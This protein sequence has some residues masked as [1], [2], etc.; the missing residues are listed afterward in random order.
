MTKDIDP[1]VLHPMTTHRYSFQMCILEVQNKANAG[2]MQESLGPWIWRLAS[3]GLL[4]WNATLDVRGIQWNHSKH[5]RNQNLWAE[6][7]S[8]YWNLNVVEVLGDAPYLL[9]MLAWQAPQKDLRANTFIE[10]KRVECREH[11]L[12]T[13]SYTFSTLS[14]R[15]CRD[16][17]V[18]IQAPVRYGKGMCIISL[19]L[20]YNS[21]LFAVGKD[22]TTKNNTS[23]Q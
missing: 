11:K 19:P 16:N 12:I 22:I 4:I 10:K 20:L 15:L 6:E 9:P 13:S 1:L 7:L 14:M 17:F 18:P 5:D 21:F 3:T 23:S 8:D 2:G